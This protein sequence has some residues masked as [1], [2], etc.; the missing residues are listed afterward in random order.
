MDQTRMAP[1]AK[2]PAAGRPGSGVGNVPFAKGIMSGNLG[3]NQPAPLARQSPGNR[4]MNSQTSGPPP[5]AQNGQPGAVPPGGPAAP[6]G[7]TMTINPEVYMQMMDAYFQA[8]MEAA[9]QPSF[10]LYGKNY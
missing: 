1:G 9:E 10:G 6:P 5:P 8:I 3:T 2:A 4:V 7:G